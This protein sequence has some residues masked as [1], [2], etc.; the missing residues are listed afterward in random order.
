M[1]ETIHVHTAQPGNLFMLHLRTILYTPFVL[2][3]IL[4]YKCVCVCVC[5]CACVCVC[6]CVCARAR[7][8]VRV[9]V[10]EDDAIVVFNANACTQKMWEM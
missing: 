9:R 10:C 5:V 6:V 2:N 7:V 1:Q 8:R 4:H 3:Y